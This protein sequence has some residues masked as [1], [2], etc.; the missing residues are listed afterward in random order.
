MTQAGNIVTI[1]YSGDNRVVLS[2]L[3]GFNK[4]DL[5]VV[6]LLFKHGQSIPAWIM[7]DSWRITQISRKL[8]RSQEDNKPNQTM[9]LK[10]K[11][12]LTTSGGQS[13]EL[14]RSTQSLVDRL[15]LDSEDISIQ[16]VHPSIMGQVNFS[17]FEPQLNENPTRKLCRRL[18]W[19]KAAYS[20]LPVATREM[21]K[22]LI[23]GYKTVVLLICTQSW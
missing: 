9:D 20:P 22:L 1:N 18:Q 11:L 14:I 7:Y 13:Y 23:C 6:T 12:G 10:R 8:K 19:I 5:K 21:C 4:L 17:L 2:A 16:P 3:V 15:N